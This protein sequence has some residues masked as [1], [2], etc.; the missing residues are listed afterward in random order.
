MLKDAT[1]EAPRIK[2]IEEHPVVLGLAAE[3][4]VRRL[5]PL[6]SIRTQPTTMQ[7]PG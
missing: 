2:T 3:I 7:E 4:L 6:V 1:A 5:S